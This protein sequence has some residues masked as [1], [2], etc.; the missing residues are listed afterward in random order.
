MEANP[1]P[2]KSSLLNKEV[3]SK[4]K[5]DLKNLYDVLSVAFDTLGPAKDQDLIVAIGNTGCGKSTMLSSLIYGTDALEYK[6]ISEEVTIMKKDMKTKKMVEHKR[7]RKRWVIEQKNPQGEFTIGHSVATSCTFLP[8]FKKKNETSNILYADIAG[9][10]DAGGEL[11][12]Y[13]NCFVNKKLFSLASR[14]RFLFPMPFGQ[15]YQD[16]GGQILDQVR[17][18]QKVCQESPATMVNSVLP[19]LTKCKQIEPD[20]DNEEEKV[21]LESVKGMLHECFLAETKR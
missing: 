13:I 4:M 17:V 16:R 2:S 15:L 18:L 12:D 3:V 19:I 1:S 21:D 14:V 7:T 20:D 11:F 6:Q 8:H 10:C 9:L 5:C